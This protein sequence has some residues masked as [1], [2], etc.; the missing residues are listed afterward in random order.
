MVCG[1]SCC[2]RERHSTNVGRVVASITHLRNC[3][4]SKFKQALKMFLWKN[5]GSKMRT[6]SASP[7]L[8]LWRKPGLTEQQVRGAAVGPKYGPVACLLTGALMAELCVHEQ[9]PRGGHRPDKTKRPWGPL[10][11]KRHQVSPSGA[12][13]CS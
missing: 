3:A 2:I 7:S 5:P 11:G 12:W 9:F 8:L 10:L 13:R 4:R 6:C 1:T